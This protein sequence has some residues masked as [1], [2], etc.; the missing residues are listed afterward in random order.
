MALA[1][2]ELHRVAATFFA[3]TRDAIAVGLASFHGEGSIGGHY[4]NLM[5]G[6]TQVG[7]GA[8]VANGQLTF[9][10]DFR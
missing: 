3:S 7:C 8:F 2:N 4:K 6:Y 10:Q 5:G 9:V 1:E